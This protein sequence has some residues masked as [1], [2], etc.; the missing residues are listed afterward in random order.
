MLGMSA[1]EERSAIGGGGW[2]NLATVF[3]SVVVVVQDLSCSAVKLFG[4]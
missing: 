1:G 3:V 2:T 4:I